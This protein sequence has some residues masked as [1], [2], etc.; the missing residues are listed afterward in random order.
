MP[1]TLNQE[2]SKPCRFLEG[3]M[4]AF[5]LKLV[6]SAKFFTAQVPGTFCYNCGKNT[7]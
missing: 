6:L 7:F 4:A 3:K 5:K 2:V 1:I